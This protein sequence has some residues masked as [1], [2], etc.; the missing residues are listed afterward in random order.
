MPYLIIE[1]RLAENVTDYVRDEKRH[2]RKFP[3]YGAAVTFAMDHCDQRNIQ[4]VIYRGERKA[5]R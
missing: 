2:I 1:E 3:T 4:T 5:R